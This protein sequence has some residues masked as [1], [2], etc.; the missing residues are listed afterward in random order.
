MKRTSLT[1][2]SEDNDI[3]VVNKPSGLLSIPDRFKKD[4]PNIR[5]ILEEKYGKIFVVHRLDKDT[6]GVMVF[7]RHADSHRNLSMQFEHHSIDKRYLAIMAGVM[8]KDDV[9]IDI[10]LMPNP[11]VPGTM[12]PSARGKASHTSVHVLERFRV[13]TYVECQL[14]TG[15]QH[16][17]RVHCAAIGFPLLVDATYGRSSEF[18]LS[19]IKRRYRLQK[20][21][22]EQP[23]MSRTTLH[24][25]SL[26]FTHPGS[27]EACTFVADPPKDFKALLTVLRKYSASMSAPVPR[28]GD[29]SQ[30]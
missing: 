15:R 3:V 25:H 14:K 21:V 10:P 7:A 20:D 18:R 5:R 22:E 23:I 11:R 24:A 1:I 16:Q 17:L 12:M 30:L 26:S 2:L 9:D 13:A 27:G 8:T 4:E 6:S 29:R 28:G 19:Q